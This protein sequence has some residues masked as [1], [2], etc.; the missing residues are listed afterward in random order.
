MRLVPEGQFVFGMQDH[1]STVMSESSSGQRQTTTHLRGAPLQTLFL[2]AFWIDTHEVTEQDYQTYVLATGAERPHS[3]LSFQPKE[4][5]TYIGMRDCQGYCQWS[6]KRICLREEWEKAA[7]G[8]QGWPMPWGT[9]KATC[10]HTQMDDD[11]FGGNGCGLNRPAEVGSKPRDKSVFGVLDM[12]GN[13]SEWV[14]SEDLDRSWAKGYDYTEDGFVTLARQFEHD[15]EYKSATVGC[16]CCA[17][18]L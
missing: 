2:P 18:A 4:P 16:R 10:E 6:Q 5:V 9:E 15:Y 12:A 17:D 11:L 13:V 3:L 1:V 7:R 14:Y 8:T